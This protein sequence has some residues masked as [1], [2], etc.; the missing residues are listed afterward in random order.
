MPKRLGEYWYYDE[1]DIEKACGN[2]T[3]SINVKFLMS[4]MADMTKEYAEKLDAYER[5]YIDDRK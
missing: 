5:L 3:F 1:E 4:K 2:N